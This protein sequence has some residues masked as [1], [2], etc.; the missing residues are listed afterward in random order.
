MFKH[1]QFLFA[2]L[3]PLPALA[4]DA[5]P[6]AVVVEIPTPSGAPRAVIEAGI[7]RAVPDYRQ[8]PGLITKYFTIGD[9]SFGGVYLFTTR[10]AATTWFGEAWRARVEKTYGVPASLTYFDV[11]VVLNN[12]PVPASMAAR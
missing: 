1:L 11:P 5:P 9:G 6:V 2:T 12:A 7:K 3:A 8:V 4:V 10:A